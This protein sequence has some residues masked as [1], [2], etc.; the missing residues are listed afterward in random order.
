MRKIV[1]YIFLFF[2]AFSTKAQEVRSG[3]IDLSNVDLENNAVAL[4]GEWEFYWNE[5][6]SPDS[7]R[8]FEKDYYPFPN[9]H[10]YP[11]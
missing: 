11:Y 7:I 3:V 5:L 10:K 9:F 6:I 2:V 4:N 8:Y 1:P